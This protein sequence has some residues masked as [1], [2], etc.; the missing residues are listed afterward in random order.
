MADKTANSITGNKKQGGKLDSC[1]SV[2]IKDAEL[3]IPMPNTESGEP[4][5][6][7]FVKIDELQP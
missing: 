7:S 4:K 2:T 1:K 5:A 6:A 3:T